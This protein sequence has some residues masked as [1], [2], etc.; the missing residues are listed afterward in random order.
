M[1]N[2]EDV[3]EHIYDNNLYFSMQEDLVDWT[4]KDNSLHLKFNTK[5]LNIDLALKDQKSLEQ[6]ATSFYFYTKNSDLFSWNCKNVF[7]FIVNRTGMNI[8]SKIIYDLYIICSY[9][10]LPK[11]KPKSLKEAST[12]IGYVKNSKNWSIFENIYREVYFPLISKVLPTIENNPLI[13]VEKRSK[14]YAYYEV[15]GQANGRMKNLSLFKDGYMPHC[16]SAPQK[17][18]LNLPDDNDYF[19]SLDYKNMEVSVLQWLSNDDSLVNMNENGDFY[20]SLWHFLTGTTPSETQR[21]FAKKIFLPVIY[22]QKSF[23]LSN[24]LGISKKNAELLIYKLEKKFSKSFQ[25]VQSQTVENNFAFDIFGRRRRFEDDEI[26]KVRNFCIQSP[27]NIVCLRKLVKLYESIKDF[28]KICFHVHDGYVI[29]CNR[30]ELLKTIKLAT[31][32]LEEEDEMFN[33]LKLK[34]SCKY[35]KKLNNLK[36]SKEVV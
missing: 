17:N 25:W 5:N 35:G 11:S 21:S 26:Y 32:V 4:N 28:A 31:K 13:D 6:F 12:I 15:E 18:N 8:Q 23:S 9:F 16:L 27:S 24:K 3:L 34:V 20:E 30:N 14:V 29:S 36:D 7:S 2:I 10:C 33:G 22:G 1:Q 19:L